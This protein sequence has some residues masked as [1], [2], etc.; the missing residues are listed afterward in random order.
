LK[1]AVRMRR[2]ACVFK[3]IE[4]P[5]FRAFILQLFQSRVTNAHPG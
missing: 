3:K 1:P 5:L 2:S 4:R